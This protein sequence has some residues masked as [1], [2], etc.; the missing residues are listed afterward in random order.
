MAVTRLSSLKWLL[1]WHFFQPRVENILV[2]GN[3]H[4]VKLNHKRRAR[5]SCRLFIVWAEG[6]DVEGGGGR[7]GAVGREGDS[8]KEGV[9][10]KRDR[11]WEQGGGG[12]GGQKEVSK[13]IVKRTG[14]GGSGRVKTGQGGA[15]RG[16]A[17]HSA[18]QHYPNQS[19]TAP[20]PVTKTFQGEGDPEIVK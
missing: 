18:N 14:P 7:V 12:V 11:K 4:H 8:K 5:G 1:Y 20:L 2:P 19:A 10:V 17:Q 15:G 6:G 13:G 3:R 9:G 16:L